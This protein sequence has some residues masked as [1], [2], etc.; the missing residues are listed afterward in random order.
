[1]LFYCENGEITTN[2]CWRLIF[3]KITS[4][5]CLALFWGMTVGVPASC[6]YAEDLASLVA[7]T[8]EN[9]LY[10]LEYEFSKPLFI[11]FR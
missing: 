6:K 4:G 2:A 10:Y 1:M 9:F 3:Q 5:G 11:R 7:N 8:L